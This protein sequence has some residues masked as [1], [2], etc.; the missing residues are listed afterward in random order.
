MG[1]AGVSVTTVV[2]AFVAKFIFKV[3][4]GKYEKI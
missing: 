3:W 1:A 4:G 2:V